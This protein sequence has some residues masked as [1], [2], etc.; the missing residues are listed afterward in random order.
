MRGT[1]KI[2]AGYVN[3]HFKSCFMFNNRMC[4]TATSKIRDTIYTANSKKVV[5]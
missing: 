1:F 2:H 5:N 3:V 4:M